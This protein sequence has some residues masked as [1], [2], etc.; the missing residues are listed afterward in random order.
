ME[1][2]SLI[3]IILERAS[4]SCCCWTIL[5][6]NASDFVPCSGSFCNNNNKHLPS[7]PKTIKG[8]SKFFSRSK[9][10]KFEPRVTNP[11]LIPLASFSYSIATMEYSSYESDS[12]CASI[13]TIEERRQRVIIEKRKQRD[14]LAGRDPFERAVKDAVKEKLDKF[15]PL[16]PTRPS[17]EDLANLTE[18]EKDAEKKKFSNEY[19]RIT[20]QRNYAKADIE[21]A[22]RRQM[23]GQASPVVGTPQASPVVGT[24]TR[25]RGVTP[26]PMGTPMP[27]QMMDFGVGETPQCHRTQSLFERMLTQVMENNSQQTSALA[28]ALIAGNDAARQDTQEKNTSALAAVIAENKK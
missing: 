24:P 9:T 23:Q 17:E 7:C 2:V 8:Y 14:K 3:S 4:A 11:F 15:F 25:H 27:V 13:S 18:E 19:K 26:S 22:I 1:V 16:P 5:Y 6:T 21:L 12:S 20:N 28:A 10:V